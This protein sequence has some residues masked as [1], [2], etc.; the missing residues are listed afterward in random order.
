[1]SL[2]RA[3]SWIAFLTL[4]SKVIAYGRDATMAHFFGATDIT[5]AYAIAYTLPGFALVMLGGLNGPFH[6][7]V[8]S[9]LGRYDDEAEKRRILQSLVVVTAVVMGLLSVLGIWGSEWLVWLMAP[10][11]PKSSM[12]MA[13]QMTQVMFPMFFLAGL[14]GI[15]YGVLNL[16]QE[17]TLP[18]LSPAVAS[19]T[20]IVAMLAW[21]R[22]VGPMVLAWSTLV[23]AVAG[24]STVIAV[25]FWQ[26]ITGTKG[27]SFLY[28]MPLALVAQMAVGMLVS[29]IP[30]GKA[31]QPRQ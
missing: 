30:I 1:M 19:V 13:V 24:L 8:V 10:G 9:V 15:S 25:N 17:Y 28:A 14:I 18:S 31:T 5:D 4:I 7:A 2:L 26:E 12:T 29:L 27:I 21:G 16:R 11:L 3:A 6:S 20:I 23:G 22:S